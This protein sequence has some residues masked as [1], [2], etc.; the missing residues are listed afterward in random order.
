MPLPFDATLKDL[1]TRYL[2]DWLT[3]LRL[4]TRGARVLTPDLSTVSAFSDLVI[5]LG[6][7]LLHLDFQS[8]QMKTLL[9]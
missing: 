7:R 1:V 6:R 9:S 3:S 4:P 8:A 5:R 2:R